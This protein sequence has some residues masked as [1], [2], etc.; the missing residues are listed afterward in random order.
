MALEHALELIGKAPASAIGREIDSNV[1]RLFESRD[2]L[3]QAARWCDCAAVLTQPRRDPRAP[4]GSGSMAP[5]CARVL[6]FGSHGAP[7]YKPP[8]GPRGAGSCTQGPLRAANSKEK[9]RV[10]LRVSAFF[11]LKKNL[12]TPLS[13]KHRTRKKRGRDGASERQPRRDTRAPGAL[14][15][16]LLNALGS[17]TS[18][19]MGH[20]GTSP[21]WGRDARAHA[22]KGPL[23]PRPC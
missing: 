18:G 19:L 23:E 13:Y 22:P 1:P 2:A 9:S 10:L 3:A 14:G 5:K 6:D 11:M 17:L 12:R 7:W 21:V 16:W 8:L 4:W 20:H 15:A